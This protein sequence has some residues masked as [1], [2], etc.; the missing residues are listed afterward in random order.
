MSRSNAETERAWIDAWNELYELV[1]GVAGCEFALPDGESADFEA[2]KGWLQRS[3]Y[4]GFCVALRRYQRK[5][6]R[7][8]VYAHRWAQGAPEPAWVAKTDDGYRPE[9]QP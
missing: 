4:E 6:G 9:A 1:E 7:R 2:C 3:A 5:D 8:R